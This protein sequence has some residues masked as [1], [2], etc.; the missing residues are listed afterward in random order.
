MRTPVKLAAF[1]G[2]LSIAF[3]AALGVGAA[4]GSPLGAG[5]EPAHEHEEPDPAAAGPADEAAPAPGAA[6][7]GIGDEQVPAGLALS[8]SGYALELRDQ[9]LT[10]GR[11]VELGVRIVG[12]DGEA[13]RAFDVDHDERMHVILVRR[14]TT[15][16]QH[17]H[18][19]MGADGTWTVPVDLDPGS[20]RVLADFVPAAGPAGGEALTL[21][22][23]LSVAGQYAPSP[24]PSTAR[25]DTVDG[26]T[27][28]LD[29]DLTTGRDSTMT[30]TVTRAGRPVSDLQPYLGAYGHL[31]ALRAGDLAYLHVHPEGE[32]AAS[33]TGGPDVAFSASAPTPGTYRLFLDFRHDGQVRTA[34]FTLVLDAATGSTGGAAPPPGA[35]DDGGHSGDSGQGGGDATAESPTDAHG[36]DEHSHQ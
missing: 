3:A 28:T 4:T 18:P 27:V 33:A 11:D 31:V 13:I 36:G 16:F 34:E 15:G 12:D 8:Q 19:E 9:I 26:Y 29:G 32:P 35:A 7:M 21:G 23:D 10:A 24:L 5:D 30:F 14:D 25:T 6:A 22:A 1:G 20:W 17:V 2:V